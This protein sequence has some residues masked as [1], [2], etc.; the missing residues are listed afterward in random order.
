MSIVPIHMCEGCEGASIAL[1]ADGK[2]YLRTDWQ[3]R[4]PITHC[5][6]CGEKLEVP[7]EKIEVSR[8]VLEDWA[9][10]LEISAE[11]RSSAPRY[12][13]FQVV[14]HIRTILDDR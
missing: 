4:V 9:A 8:K 10:K 14:G 2:W 3:T 12:T 5:P 1:W 6:Y 13:M 7:D 11:K